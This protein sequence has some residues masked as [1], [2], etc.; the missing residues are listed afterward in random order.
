[1]DKTAIGDYLGEEK[2]LNKKVLYE[3]INEFNF[4]NVP[5]VD[6]MKKMLSGF[7]LPGEG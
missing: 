6:A 4:E 5:F 1:L 7:R 2:D 3:Y